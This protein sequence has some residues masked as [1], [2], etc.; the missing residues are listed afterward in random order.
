MVVG[1]QFILP[2]SVDR[3]YCNMKS[4]F[5]PF[6][7]D[8]KADWTLSRIAP[9]TGYPLCLLSNMRVPTAIFV[10][11]VNG[12]RWNDSGSVVK[13]KR[14]TQPPPWLTSPSSVQHSIT[15]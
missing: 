6:P 5:S 15:P 1:L 11:N 3:F 2:D 13:L 4:Y 14:P 9:I 10:T 8:L 7:M 12:K